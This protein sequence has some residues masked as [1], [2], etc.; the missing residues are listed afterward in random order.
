MLRVLGSIFA[1]KKDKNDTI[2]KILDYQKC[3]VWI[4]ELATSF[5]NEV[6]FEQ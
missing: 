4:V 6:G 3:F 2:F 1:F 5:H